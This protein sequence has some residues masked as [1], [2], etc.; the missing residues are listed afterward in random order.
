MLTKWNLKIDN[1]SENSL[2]EIFNSQFENSN[3]ILQKKKIFFLKEND[4][5]S[6]SKDILIE[7]YLI[8]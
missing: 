7:K 3:S 6:L 2:I 1:Q 4:G 8:I 5:D